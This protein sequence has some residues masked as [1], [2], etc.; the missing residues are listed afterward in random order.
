MK[1]FLALMAFI[2]CMIIASIT[3]GQD[4]V[5]VNGVCRVNMPVVRTVTRTRTRTRAFNVPAFT[6]SQPFFVHKQTSF[7]NVSYGVQSY[8]SAGY[9]AAMNYGSSGTLSGNSNFNFGNSWVDTHLAEHIG[10]M[11]NAQ[12]HA[13]HDSLH[14]GRMR[15]GGP[16]RN[17]FRRWRR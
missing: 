13:L 6:V 10:E 12:K 5:C 9:N 2:I 4:V 7:Q 16:I 14:G 8:G 17:L 3:S 11:N 1:S 15:L